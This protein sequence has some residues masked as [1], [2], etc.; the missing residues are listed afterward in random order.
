[1]F[2][3]QNARSMGVRGM[4]TLHTLSQEPIPNYIEPYTTQ[5]GFLTLRYQGI[6]LHH[7]EQALLEAEAAVKALCQAGAD[8]VH[9]LVGLGLG[10]VLQTLY[11][12]SDGIIVV[13][14]PYVDLLRF[15]LEHVNLSAILASSRVY[16]VTDAPTMAGQIRQLFQLGL[17]THLDVVMLPAYGKLLGE[18]AYNQLA[19][20]LYELEGEYILQL[21]SRHRYGQQWLAHVLDNTSILA[22]AFPFEG[23]KGQYSH[24]PALVVD[25]GPSL[26]VIALHAVQSKAIVLATLPAAIR[27]LHAQLPPD[28]VLIWDTEPVPTALLQ[29]LTQSSI[30]GLQVILPVWAHHSWFTLTDMGRWI[31]SDQTVPEFHHWLETV[32]GEPLEALPV[33]RSTLTL[34]CH[35]M[36]WMGCESISLIGTQWET[37][38]D[39]NGQLVPV[40]NNRY[41]VTPDV[42]YTLRELTDFA[43]QCPVSV[44]KLSLIEP[45]PVNLPGFVVQTLLESKPWDN[46]P[47]IYK[48]LYPLRSAFATGKSQPVL[49][50]LEQAIKRFI[51][52][53]DTLSTVDTTDATYFSA[54]AE[55]ESLLAQHSLIRFTV[56]GLCR[57]WLQQPAEAMSHDALHQSR[58]QLTTLLDH[59]LFQHQ[60]QPLL[61]ESEVPLQSPSVHYP[62][63]WMGHTV[64]GSPETHWVLQATI[65]QWRP[66]TVILVNIETGTALFVDWLMDYLAYGRFIILCNQLPVNPPPLKHGRFLLQLDA[67]TQHHITIVQQEG[68]VLWCQPANSPVQLDSP[69]RQCLARDETVSFWLSQPEKLN[70]LSTS[71]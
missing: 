22:G 6:W 19:R 49:T 20:Y 68:R 15:V 52:L 71:K 58:V 63:Q 50:A 37:P 21:R 43:Q 13:Y 23:L 59:A 16:L 11:E 40:E 65:K 47:P 14:E 10:Y 53:C 39:F 2:F 64:T 5:D 45:L 3:E 54:R 62:S 67:T 4:G 69:T 35:L 70:T 48:A 56:G 7:P 34:G 30:P 55:L 38:P 61:R 33:C 26:D 36:A 60:V 1:M 51:A 17:I 32:Y 31:V 25:P 29:A 42:Y 57:H 66:D 46:L 27:L 9:V 12:A 24:L 41:A 28:F 44:E 8:R 18:A